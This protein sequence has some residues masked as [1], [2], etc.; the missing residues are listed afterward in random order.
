MHTLTLPDARILEYDLSGPE[1]GPVLLFHHGTPGSDRPLGVLE[2]AAHDRGL[3]LLTP[4]RPGYA[5]SSRRARRTV[6]DMVDDVS[7]LLEAL[8]VEHCVTAGWSG[9]GPHALATAARLPQ[10]VRG[11]LVIAGVAPRTV[12]DLDF[13][14][15]MGQPNIEEFG[16]AAEGEEALRA[17]LAQ[18]ASGLKDIDGPGLMKSLAG[19]I[20]DVDVA[21]LDAGLA[22]DLARD[23]AH[24]VGNGIDGWVDDDRAFVAPWGIDVADVQVPT[25]LWQG[26]DDLMVPAAH[27]HWLEQHVPGIR[28]HFV[29]GEGHVSIIASRIGP[30]LDEL[31][32][33]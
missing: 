31:L 12:E 30:M 33:A 13:L 6:A 2:S 32:G 26:S 10:R 11:A 18:D 20:P 4:A 3:R 5:G 23:F 27:G 29:S 15:G 22:V 8:G 7:A 9:G 24:A 16:A 28:A 21:V 1:G 17:H 14:G 19:L 25:F